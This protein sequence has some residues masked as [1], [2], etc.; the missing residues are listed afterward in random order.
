MWCLKLI[1]SWHAMVCRETGKMTGSP[2]LLLRGLSGGIDVYGGKVGGVKAFG[3]Y[4][5]ES[6]SNKSSHFRRTSKNGF[7]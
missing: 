2:V 3:L 7:H 6:M 1:A 5:H 4:E